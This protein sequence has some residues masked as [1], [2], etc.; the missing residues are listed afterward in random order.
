MKTRS[1]S[2]QY[3]LLRVL[4]ALLMVI[5][6]YNPVSAADFPDLVVDIETVP[7]NSDFTQSDEN[8]TYTITVTNTGVQPTSGTITLTDTLPSG[9]VAVS[10][11]SSDPWTCPTGDIRAL[12]VITCTR[13]DPILQDGASSVLT[14]TVDVNYNAGD[15]GT[16]VWE[17]PNNVLYRTVTNTVNVTG[18]GDQDASN[19]DT[20][21]TRILQKPDLRITDWELRN[22]ANTARISSPSPGEAFWVRMTI[23]NRG[24][25]IA[26]GFYPGVFLDDQPNYGIDH[27]D[28]PLYLG[29]VTDFSDFLIAP[30]DTQGF[31]DGGCLYYDPAG[32]IDPLNEDIKT[33]RGNYSLLSYL[34]DLPSN[35]STTVDVQISYPNIPEYSDAIYDTDNVRSGL[36]SGSY[37]LIMYADPTCT[38]SESYETNNSLGPVNFIVGAG[39]GPYPPTLLVNSVLPTS[40]TPVVG[41]PVTIFNT[42][43]NAGIEPAIDVALSMANKP[44]GT[45]LYNETNCATNAIIGGANPLSVIAPGGVACYI[46]TFTPSAPFAA[47]YVHIIAQAANAPSTNLL[48]GIN[49]WLLRSTSVSGP[50]TIALTTTTDFHQV[51]CSGQNAFAVASSNVGAATT[52]DITV[53]A[54]TGSVSLPLSISIMETNPNTGLVIGDN[55]LQ[56]VGAG[57]N[58]TVVVFVTFRGCVGFDPA[59]NRIFIEFRDASN[60]IVGST[61]TA[62]STNR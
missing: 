56:G 58:R 53:T 45:F 31:P 46:L 24:G 17:G 23:E 30:K 28:P 29:E 14:L 22:E 10:I 33:E 61:S 19:I 62:V 8:K 51:A 38:A 26:G 57:D 60:N 1:R 50:D 15:I 55:I 37:N 5:G 3:W 48:V 11:T 47:T 44:A 18:G 42:V 7:V 34:P 25:D 2:R 35:T 41:N 4:G 12:T 20:D 40:R 52:G 49:T 27:S 59:N 39:G 43:I 32:T 54:N 36:G 9:L 16:E 6:I 13:T 21:A